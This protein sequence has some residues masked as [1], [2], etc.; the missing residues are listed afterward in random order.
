MIGII[1]HVSMKCYEIQHE[2]FLKNDYNNWAKI[3][4]KI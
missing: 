4:L 1:I 3:W 2:V